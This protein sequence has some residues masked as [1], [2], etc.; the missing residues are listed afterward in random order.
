MELCGLFGLFG[1]M[2]C[3]NPWFG[4]LCVNG[5][6]GYIAYLSVNLYLSKY[7]LMQFVWSRYCDTWTISGHSRDICYCFS[8]IVTGF[9]ESKIPN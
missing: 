7:E 9:S 1:S 4:E 6:Y 2:D 8:N 3:V 5:L